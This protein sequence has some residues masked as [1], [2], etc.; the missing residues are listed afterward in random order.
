[1]AAVRPSRDSFVIAPGR[2]RSP[3]PMYM[4]FPRARRG[5]TLTG[6]R[7]DPP[8]P[9]PADAPGRHQV[10]LSA[11]LWGHARPPVVKLGRRRCWS[12][13]KLFVKFASNQTT[14]EQS[15]RKGR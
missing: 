14:Q 5:A 6:M 9:S 2:P 13:S 3:N 4:L 8:A 10:R 1:V 12:C 11:R 15:R 7:S